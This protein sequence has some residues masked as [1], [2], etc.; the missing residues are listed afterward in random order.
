MSRSVAKPRVNR[1]N[2]LVLTWQQ[3]VNMFGLSVS[4]PTIRAQPS[5]A[6]GSILLVVPFS[7]LANSG[8]IDRLFPVIPIADGVVVQVDIFGNNLCMRGIKE[9]IT[10]RSFPNFV[11]TAHQTT[12]AVFNELFMAQKKDFHSTLLFA[13]CDKLFIGDTYT[14]PKFFKF[15]GDVMVKATAKGMTR[16]DVLDLVGKFAQLVTQDCGYIGSRLHGHDVVRK[17]HIHTVSELNV[18]LCSIVE[19]SERIVE[20][21][22]QRV[23]QQSNEEEESVS[24][25]HATADHSVQVECV[26]DTSPPPASASPPAAEPVPLSPP[27]S[28]PAPAPAPADEPV[29]PP[30]PPPT[31]AELTPSPPAAEPSTNEST[32]A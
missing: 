8:A 28:A 1:S 16:D 10:A 11:A 21:F 15:D 7:F 4:T 24:S 3:L 5:L 13:A 6:P 32:I 31:T 20:Q 12:A 18:L 22:N 25:T 19:D 17:M 29:P 9:P 2:N 30:P 23:L 27:A 26:T 14:L